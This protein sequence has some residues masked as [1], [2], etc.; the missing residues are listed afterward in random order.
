[1]RIVIILELM[2]CLISEAGKL[3]GYIGNYINDS[4][5]AIGIVDDWRVQNRRRSEIECGK[6]IEQG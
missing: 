4:K 6:Q 2:D 3:K 1:M 5:G